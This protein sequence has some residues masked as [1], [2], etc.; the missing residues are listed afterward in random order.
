MKILAK[1]K[2]LR[3]TLF[4]PFGKTKERKM[5]RQLIQEYEQTIEELLRGLSDKNHSI[6]TEIAKL[7]EYIRGFDLVKHRHMEEAKKREKE[8]LEKFRKNPGFASLTRKTET[9]S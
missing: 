1:F 2:F 5:E 3:G 8:L 4:D 6:A 9:V 7:P